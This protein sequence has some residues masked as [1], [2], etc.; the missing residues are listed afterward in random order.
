MSA[1]KKPIIEKCEGCN[2]VVDGNTCKVYVNP[3]FMWKEDDCLMATH[4]QRAIVSVGEQK[5]NPLKA[6]KRASRGG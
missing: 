2:N 5:V 4:I 3:A 6:S 1:D